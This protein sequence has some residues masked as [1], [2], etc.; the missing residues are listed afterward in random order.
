M[1]EILQDSVLGRWNELLKEESDPNVC[2]E[3]KDSNQQD[4]DHEIQ[5]SLLPSHVDK[6]PNS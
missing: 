5:P 4:K 1:E 3:L 2:D 6:N